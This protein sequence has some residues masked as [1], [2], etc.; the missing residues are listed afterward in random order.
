MFIS[1]LVTFICLLTLVFILAISLCLHLPGVKFR[2]GERITQT[3]P[4]TCAPVSQVAVKGGREGTQTILHSPF[5]PF[6]LP[7]RTRFLLPSRAPFPLPHSPFPLPSFIPFSV[8]S[9]TLFPLPSLT[10]FSFLSSKYFLLP[11]H[12]VFPSHAFSSPLTNSLSFP[13][14]H[15]FPSPVGHSLLY[16]FFFKTCFLRLC[17]I[18]SS[19]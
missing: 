7:S 11:F 14:I 16:L 18:I 19:D 1:I 2:C 9:H 4:F 10:P 5:T 15:A 17:Q 3:R 8:S 6:S 12:A 13:L